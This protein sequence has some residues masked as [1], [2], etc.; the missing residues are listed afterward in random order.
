MMKRFVT[1]GTGIVLCARED[2]ELKGAV[3]GVVYENVFDGGLCASELFWYVWPG[4]QKGTGTRL[5]AAFEEWAKFRKC[6]R[7]TMAHMNHNM[8]DQLGAFYLRNGYVSFDT[9]YVKA[10]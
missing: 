7:V 10:I 1:E 3:A 4:A 9:N 6:T 2:F 5:L 8:A